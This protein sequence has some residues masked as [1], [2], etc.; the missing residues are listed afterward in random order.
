MFWFITC[1]L[2]M[3]V[4]LTKLNNVVYGQDNGSSVVQPA[5]SEW[6]KIVSPAEGHQV[7]VGEVLLISGE[8]SDDKSKEC[9]LSVIA[10]NI[11][12]YHAAS[13][14]GTGGANDYSK[15]NF[16]LSSN[17][18]QVKEGPNRITAKLSC[19]PLPTRWYSVNIIGI[20]KTEA[21]TNISIPTLAPS[22]LSP[23][24][25]SGV[26]L[27]PPVVSPSPVTD[28]TS[29]QRSGNESKEISI[30]F[31]VMTNPISR[32]N[33]QNITISV[34]DAVSK[35]VIS[36]ATIT[37]KLLYPGGNYVKDFSGTT[38]SDGQ[39][40]YSWII[41]KNGDIGKLTIEAKVQATSY[42][43]KTATSSFQISEG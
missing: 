22:V 41:G 34:S 19:P 14:A 1:S 16:I 36:G 11:K 21:S 20:Q 12:P 30:T 26:I 17:Y 38:G 4:T 10:N 33:R 39:F 42:E 24:N 25:E 40:V 29:N 2:V 43:S 13:P 3:V 35:E 37:G 15:W 28:G 5:V 31:D 7:P 18:T 8:S 6:V 32:G 9:G 27:T 23:T